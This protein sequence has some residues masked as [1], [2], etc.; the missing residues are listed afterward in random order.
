MRWLLLALAFSLFALPGFA[1]PLKLK[2]GVNE[3]TVWIVNRGGEELRDLRL[4]ARDDL[5]P[6]VRLEGLGDVS[7]C[8]GD[9]VPLKMLVERSSLTRI[10]I[11]RICCLMIRLLFSTCPRVW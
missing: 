10:A 7:V 6:W 2:E 5:P 9:R 1:L 3:V 4:E 11:D 8:K